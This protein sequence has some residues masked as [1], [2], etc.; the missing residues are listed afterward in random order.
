MH[1]V[2][3]VLGIQVSDLTYHQLLSVLLHGYYNTVD[4]I[5]HSCDNNTDYIP[6]SCDLLIP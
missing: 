1:N 3:L 6:Y 2:T 4:Y 5:P